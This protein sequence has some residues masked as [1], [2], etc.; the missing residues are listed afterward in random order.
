MRKRLSIIFAIIVTIF[1]AGCS[2]SGSSS[3]EWPAK[4]SL[5]IS[6]QN[7]AVSGTGSYI[8]IEDSVKN[9]AKKPIRSAI[10]RYESLDANGSVIDSSQVPIIG[11]INP[12]EEKTFDTMA[13]RLKNMNKYRIYVNEASY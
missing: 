2:S 12:N 1:T 10:L 3:S 9:L 11:P 4:D 5:I 6:S 8:R 13:K 7:A